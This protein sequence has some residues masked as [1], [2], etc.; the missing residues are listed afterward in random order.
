MKY[1]QAIPKS[2]FVIFVVVALLGA[3]Y[4]LVSEHSAQATVW[5]EFDYGYGTCERGDANSD[6]VIDID[7][8]IYILNYAF[9]DG[10]APERC[11]W[12]AVSR[13]FFYAEYA[14]RLPDG[15][16]SMMLN[17][18]NPYLHI[19]LTS[20]DP[21]SSGVMWLSHINDMKLL[22]VIKAEYMEPGDSIF[23]EW[24]E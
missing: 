14:R 6:G 10:P 8:A 2:W 22:I 11:F 17:A 4:L 21:D 24:V 12:N 18:T 1:I 19:A 5:N 16:Y 23:F 3:G 15:S 7:D 13:N 9:S 20:F